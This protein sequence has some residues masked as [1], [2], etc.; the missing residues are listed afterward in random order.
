MEDWIPLFKIFLNSPCPESDA[1]QWLQTNFNPSSNTNSIS[2]TSLLSLLTRISD[3]NSDDPSSL[4]KKRVMWVQT[5]PNVVQARIL[6]FLVYDNQRFCRND[7]CGLARTVLTQGK[8]LDFWV[9][10]AAEQLL[11]SVSLSDYRWLS[12]LNLD[13]EEENADGEFYSIPD[14]LSDAAKDNE[15][16]LP[17]LPISPDELIAERPSFGSVCNEDDLIVNGNESS[18]KQ[19]FDEVMLEFDVG[20]RNFDNPVDVEVEKTAISIKSRLHNLESTSKAVE[21]A[22]EIRELYIRCRKKYSLPVLNLIE[23]WSANDEISAVLMSRFSV[24]DLSWHSHVLCSIALPKFLILNGPC[25]RVLL[26]ATIEYCKAHHKAAEYALLLPLILRSEGVNSHICDVITRIVKECMHTAHVSAF[27]QKVLCEDKD[28]K[29]FVCLP[30]H[31]C[32]IS[33]ELVWT[34]SLFGLWRN[35]LNHDVRLVQDSVD[36]LVDRVCEFGDRYSKSLKFG[37]FVLCLVS[38]CGPFLKR[39]KVLLTEVVEKTD[40]VVTKS[41]LSKLSAL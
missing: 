34:E 28:A 31:Q 15:P 1:S 32:L 2:T 14:W 22:N 6:S 21:L 35:I 40:T 18:E 17:W 26:S 38:K 33:D 20:E 19:E 8:N 7:L 16:V 12:C 23:P 27:C 39:H 37:N 36:R 25:S 30:C 9:K 11:D 41:I 13:S 5:L 10:K 4:Q 24:D 3:A 29:R